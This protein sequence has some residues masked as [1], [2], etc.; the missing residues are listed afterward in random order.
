MQQTEGETLAFSAV[1]NR[2]VPVSGRPQDSLRQCPAVAAHRS[3]KP[4]L[5]SFNDSD[6]SFTEPC[7]DRDALRRHEGARTKP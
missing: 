4:Y 1:S 6:P 2:W 7:R 5:S 3:M